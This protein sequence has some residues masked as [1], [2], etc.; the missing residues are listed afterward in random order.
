MGPYSK[1]CVVR[2]GGKSGVWCHFHKLLK[3]R[4]DGTGRRER[5]I[6]GDSSLTP[7]TF[8]I[9]SMP[10]AQRRKKA[11]SKKSF[12]PTQKYTKSTALLKKKYKGVSRSNLVGELETEL[13]DK[14]SRSNGPFFAVGA[15]LPLCAH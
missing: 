13:A 9:G 6:F 2:R 15:F 11:F 8:S 7:P 3:G 1:S 4:R 12:F 10:A 5:R 14:R